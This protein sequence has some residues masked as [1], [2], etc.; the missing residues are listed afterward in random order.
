MYIFLFCMWYNIYR[1]KEDGVSIEKKKKIIKDVLFYVFIIGTL[2][3]WRVNFTPIIVSGHSMDTTLSDGL[4]GISRNI[5]KE[6]ELHRGDIVIVYEDDH[7]VVKRIIGLPGETISCANNKV[8]INDDL[9]EETYTS[10]ITDDF[11]EVIIGKSEYFIMG[12]NRS[13]SKD[14]RSYGA[15]SKEQIKSKGIF[16]ISSISRFG[17]VH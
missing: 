14:S 12:D 13:N 9:L 15:I 10:S 6:A 8:Y 5:N 16:V 4:I 3:Y 1:C 11:E 2:I 17:V 7:Y